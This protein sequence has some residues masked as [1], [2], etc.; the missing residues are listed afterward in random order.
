MSGQLTISGDDGNGGIAEA[1]FALTVENVAPAVT[2]SPS[3]EQSTWIRGCRSADVS[4][5]MIRDRRWRQSSE[6][7]RWT[8]VVRALVTV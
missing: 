2:A 6:P 7:Y 1:T 8:L 3:M 4:C 5:C